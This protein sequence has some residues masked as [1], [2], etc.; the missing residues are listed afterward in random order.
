MNDLPGLLRPLRV[1]STLPRGR[2]TRDA[3]PRRPR[4]LGHPSGMVEDLDPVD[5]T[6]D[7][8]GPAD[9]DVTPSSAYRPV[10]PPDLV[11]SIERMQRLTIPP[12]IFRSFDRMQRLTTAP[13]FER[14]TRMSNFVSRHD[15]EV[16][17]AEGALHQPAVRS[18]G[19]SGDRAYDAGEQGI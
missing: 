17:H 16:D 2:P 14:I 5:D 1:K 18:L 8:G 11:R 6:D 3:R 9:A 7:D 4:L 13:Q 19:H 10:L 15:R 12:D